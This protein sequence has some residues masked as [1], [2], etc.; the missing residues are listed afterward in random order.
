MGS[1]PSAAARGKAGFAVRSGRFDV[2]AAIALS[3]RARSVGGVVSVAASTFSC[4]GFPV[5]IL[6]S[7]VA[8]RRTIVW[9]SRG[10]RLGTD[11]FPVGAPPG[12]GSVLTAGRAWISWH[13]DDPLSL[14]A[15]P[16]TRLLRSPPAVRRLLVTGHCLAQP[17]TACHTWQP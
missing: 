9:T 11:W 16:I 6:G 3:R 4:P 10:A 1:R 12:R 2:D 15:G 8:M 14:P 13:R 17:N 7:S 5:R